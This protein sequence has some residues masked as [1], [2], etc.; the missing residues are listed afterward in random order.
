VAKGLP[1]EN[2]RTDHATKQRWYE[3]KQ[4]I[5]QVMP[6]PGEMCRAVDSWRSWS[7]E[8]VVKLM[9]LFKKWGTHSVWE[10][11]ETRQLFPGRTA[12][13]MQT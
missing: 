13:A 5:E 3:I 4:K 2:L 7:L 6:L 10:S 8:N 9:Q 12:C 1:Q 11:E